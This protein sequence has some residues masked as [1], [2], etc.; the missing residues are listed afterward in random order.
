MKRI[1]SIAV[2]VIVY[3]QNIIAQNDFVWFEG[4]TP[5]TYSVSGKV[6]PVV[7]IALEMFKEDMRLVTGFKPKSSSKGIIR[8]IQ[9]KNQENQ[10]Q[11]GF[12]LK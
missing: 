2:F 8:I 5:I 11:D 4:N 3:L 9:K 10:S 7:K 6:D 1:I 12:L